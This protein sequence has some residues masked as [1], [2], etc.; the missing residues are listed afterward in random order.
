MRGAV[1]HGMASPSLLP[2]PDSKPTLP[3]LS[4]RDRRTGPHWAATLVSRPEGT[5]NAS[6]QSTNGCMT[7][8]Y[9]VAA[10]P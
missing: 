5:A 4:R 2:S 8:R 3:Q 1:P 6:Q 9:S 10:G 7:L